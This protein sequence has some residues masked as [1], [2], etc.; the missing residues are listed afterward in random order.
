MSSYVLE[1]ARACGVQV[2]GLT[3]SSREVEPGFV[4]FALKG[5]HVDGNLFIEE[6]I[7]RGA[8]VIVS[9]FPAGREYSA[10]YI[11]TADIDREMAD[12]AYEFYGRPSDHMTMLGITGTK[13]KTSIAYLLESI[14]RTNGEKVGV[15]GTVNYRSNG[16]VLCAAPNTTPA[17]LPLFK[18]LAQMRQDGCNAVVMEVSSHALEQQRVRHIWYD[19]AVFTNLQRD[20]LDYHHTFENYFKA[21]QKLFENLADPA[22][23]KPNRT[24]V[25]NADDPYGCRLVEQVKGRVHVVTYGMN[26]AADFQ[27]DRVQEFLTH[28]S[29]C[30]NGRPMQINLLGR[31]NVYNALAAYAVARVN[32][33]P[34][35]AAAA[36]LKALSGVPGRM[37]R[38]DVGQNFFAFVDFA[39]TDEALQRAFDTLEPFKKGRI[40]LVFG[41]GGQRD[42]TKRPLMGKTACTRADYVFLTNDNPRCEDEKQIFNDILAGMQGKTNYEVVP[43]RAEA[44]CRALTHAHAQDIVLV[45]G[46]GHE[47]YQI[48]GTEKRHFSDQETIRTFLRGNR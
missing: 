27:A 10:L 29:F 23:Q 38:I 4:F 42:R 2:T 40:L 36:G 33:V 48:I 19:T 41:C 11:Q 15:F 1:K 26:T 21:K 14:L 3:F 13:G 22:N 17:A 16:H 18:R 30:I 45:A 47:D 32:G 46:K 5:A 39:Y 28:T 9:A 34:E 37:E 43:D 44:I 24:A 8:R 31:H 25:I 7:A 20:H 6:A 35:E 12:A